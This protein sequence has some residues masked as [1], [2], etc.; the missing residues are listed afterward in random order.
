M[1]TIEFQEQLVSLHRPLLHFALGLTKDRANAQDLVQESM[2]RA[3]L[4][5]DQFQENTNFKAWLYTIVRNTFINEHRRAKRKQAMME[6]VERTRDTVR[7]VQTPATTESTMVR[8]EIDRS[9]RSLDPAFGIP[10]TMHHEGFKYQEIAERMQIPIGTV[11]SRIHQ[12]RHRLMDRLTE[13]TER[14]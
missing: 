7:R 10:F 2:L 9:L 13:A 8:S 4:Y 3:L 1:S 11:K 14:A 6:S 12:A 5:R